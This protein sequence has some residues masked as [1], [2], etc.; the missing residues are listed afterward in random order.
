[1]ATGIK[2]CVLGEGRVGK[3]SLLKRFFNNKFD[4]SEVSTNNPSHFQKEEINKN[5]EKI[6]INIWDT[7]GQDIFDSLN[8]IYYKDAVAALLV[9]DVSK[10]NDTFPKVEKW[11]REIIEVN[12]NNV[13]FVLCG[14]KYDLLNSTDVINQNNQYINQFCSKYNCKHFFTSAKSGKNVDEAFQVLINYMKENC[15]SKTQ[16]NR[17]LKI[18]KNNLIEKNNKKKGCC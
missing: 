11:A 16:S 6:L 4:S 5:G 14:N 8:T 17:G 1:M 3:T 9:Y 2:G 13:F 7:A 12:T 18:D 10:F 15:K